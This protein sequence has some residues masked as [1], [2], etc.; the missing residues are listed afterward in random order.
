MAKIEEARLQYYRL[1]L[2]VGP[3][4]SGKTSVLQEVS[5]RVTVPLVNVNLELARRLLEISPQQR[6]FKVQKLLADIISEIKGDVALL[7]NLELL[8]DVH[9]NQD[10]LRLLQQ[11]SRNKTIVATWNGAV[12][13][14]H[15]TY[16]S[17][18]HPEY[19]KYSLSDT[20]V[21][22]L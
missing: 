8:F 16:A 6:P 15:L 19:K 5:K 21:V 9:L 10:P 4:G 7:D 1:V 3:M 20:L 13:E 11:L 2:L 22:P 12:S 17:P 18:N 14:G